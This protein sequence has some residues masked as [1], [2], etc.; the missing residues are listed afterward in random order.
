[1]HVKDPIP[2]LPPRLRHWQRFMDRALAKSPAR[3]FRDTR[4]MHEAL[5]KVP[6]RDHTREM[7]VLPAL[8]RGAGFLRHMPKLAWVGLLLLAAG[9][10]GM[11]LRGDGGAAQDTSRRGASS[12][13]TTA[14]PSIPQSPAE[15]LPAPATKPGQAT[16]TDPA[17]ALLRAAPASSAERWVVAADRQIRANRLTSPGNDNAYDSLLA[18]QKSDASYLALPAAT[19]RFIDAIGNDALRR[20][21][22]NDIA[23]AGSQV[24]A[25]MR[26]AERTRQTTSPAVVRLRA[27]VVR[28][29][30]LRIDAAA[31]DYDHAAAAHTAANAKAL[32]VDADETKRLAA[33]AERIPKPGERIA[34]AAGL[35]LVR[36]GDARFGAMSQPVSRDDYT[37]FTNATHRGEALCRD[38]AS[39]LRIVSPRDW[40]S[41]GFAQVGSQP[42]VCVSWDDAQAYARWRSGQDGRQYRLPNALEAKSMPAP[43]AA[44]RAISEWANDCSGDCEH[45]LA[46]GRSWR[47]ADGQRPLEGDRGYDDVGIRLV[48]DL[49]RRAVER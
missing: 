22:D 43:V 16:T 38:R 30:E 49:P 34:D 11:Y 26:V 14:S 17:D 12:S 35:V 24:A 39:L 47:T 32:G 48:S 23:Q 31:A 1:M 27:N 46:N 5:D 28:A 4:H 15:A 40:K 10:I 42:V 36:D 2:R 20:I 33:L 29:L 18:A 37:R 41:P 6:R 3:R 25:A 13:A 19:E 44:A 8:R 45:H 7:P 21:A 9:A